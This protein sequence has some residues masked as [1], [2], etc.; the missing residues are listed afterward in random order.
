MQSDSRIQVEEE[1]SVGIKTIFFSSP[2]ILPWE[3]PLIEDYSVTGP[4]ISSNRKLM[5]AQVTHIY[6]GAC[7]GFRVFL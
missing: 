1:L 5:P 3:L 2:K 6:Q 4:I 7:G